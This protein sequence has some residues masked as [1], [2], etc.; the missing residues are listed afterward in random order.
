M[1][2]FATL[3]WTMRWSE[4]RIMLKYVTTRYVSK[5]QVSS[6]LDEKDV[7]RQV[8]L[9]VLLVY[10]QYVT[11][12]QRQTGWY[13]QY[14]QL[15]FVW[16]VKPYGWRWWFLCFELE[17]VEPL[18]CWD[19]AGGVRRWRPL[20]G[21]SSCFATGLFI[22]VADSTTIADRLDALRPNQPTWPKLSRAEPSR[23]CV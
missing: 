23:A 2:E 1:A 3:T 16:C 13:F 8:K 20:R 22:N 10:I 4:S 7:N 19:W 14:S 15:F 6:E 18:C 17:H 5:Y 12:Q 21:Y 9:L 11:A